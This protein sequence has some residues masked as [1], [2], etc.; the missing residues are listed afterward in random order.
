VNCNC[1]NL[2]VI[3]KLCNGCQIDTYFELFITG[4]FNLSESVI[5]PELDFS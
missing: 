3:V 4:N 2:G 5:T 1:D